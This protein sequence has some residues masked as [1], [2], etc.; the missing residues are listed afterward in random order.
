MG[1][2]GGFRFAYS[3][4][5][6]TRSS[7]EDAIPR[8]AAAG[9]EGVEILADE[10][11]LNPMRSSQRRTVRIRSL[12][13]ECGLGVSN[14]NV[15]TNLALSRRDPEGFWPGLL[16]PDP[17]QRRRRIRYIQRA[18]ELAGELG[19]PSISIAL[20]RAP[21]GEP[22][23]QTLGR[24]E[25]SLE[26]VLRH[27]ERCRV[28]VGIEVEPGH[29][30]ESYE[31]LFPVVE[32]LDHP[33]LGAN[34]DIGH[35]ACAGEDVPAGIRKWRGRIWNLHVEDIREKVHEHLV[36]GLGDIDFVPVF[37]ALRETGYGG[38]LTLELYPYRSRPTWAG[39]KGLEY[40]KGVLADGVDLDKN[41]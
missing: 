2:G 15:N 37:G 36:P 12:L 16:E 25:R 35:A 34:L 14:L 3:S 28:N 29:F 33:R 31:D 10:P 1:V 8:I 21:G 26:A 39:R 30:L 18:L 19:A 41:T 23:S 9:F 32:R 40:L 17:G 4:N 6:Y 13:R 20:G 7:L 5:A 27:A 11:H 22:R 38:F 24:L